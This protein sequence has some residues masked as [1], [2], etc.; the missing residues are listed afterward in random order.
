VVSVPSLGDSL[1]HPPGGHRNRGA[2]SGR[3][4]ANQLQVASNRASQAG[5]WG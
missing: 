1:H 5:R 3:H 4:V 2:R